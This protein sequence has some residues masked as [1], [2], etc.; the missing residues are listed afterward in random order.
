[1]T[2]GSPAAPGMYAEIRVPDPNALARELVVIPR[3]ALI[4]RGSLPMVQVA[5]ATDEKEL[6][7]V[8]LG[9]RL[10]ERHV[11]VLSG[12]RSGERIYATPHR[13]RGD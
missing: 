10:D 11:S 8:R 6:R 1:L 13:T 2:P 4:Y 12:L 3:S 5:T 7:L 9:E